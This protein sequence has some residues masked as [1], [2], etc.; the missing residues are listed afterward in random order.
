MTTVEQKIAPPER[1]GGQGLDHNQEE[2]ANRAIIALLTDAKEGHLTD[3]VAT[4]RHGPPDE[5]AM[6]TAGAY[7]VWAQRGMVR[8]RRFYEPDG[9]YGYEVIEQVGENPIGNQ[10]PTALATLAEE[11]EAGAKSGFSGEDPA[12]AFVEPAHLSHPLAYER[13]A[14][15]FDSP[16]GPD[17]VV[18]PK[19]YAWGRQPGQH[20]SIDVVQSRAPLVFSGPGIRHGTTDALCAQVDVAPTLAKLLD[21]PLIDGMDSTGRT[22]SERGVAPDVYLKRQDGRVIESVLDTERGELRSRPERVYVFLL[23]GLSNTE[24]KERLEHDRESIPALSRL[25]DHGAF[26]EYGTIVNFP[27]I[28]WPSHNALGTGAWC[29]HH[30]IVNP[31]YHLRETKETITP[32]GMTWDT[33]RFLGAGVETFY[34]AVHRVRGKWDPVTKQGAVTASI[35]EPCSRGAAH[36]TL[37][38]QLLVSGEAIR[39]VARENK[40]DTNARWKAEA[41]EACYR[42]SGTD[43][44]GLAQALLLFDNDE[45]PP[46]TFTYHEF[47]LNDSVGHDYGPH[48]DAVRDSLIETDKRISKILALLDRKG[49]FDSTLFV[50]TTDHGMAPID[51][52]LAA[53]QVRAVPDAGIKS[54]TCMPLVY[55]IDMDVTVSAAPDGRTVTVTVVD[56]DS[57]AHGEKVPVGGARVEVAA[58]HARVV[59]EARTDAYGVAG[60]PLP[61]DID[62]VD[63]VVVVH[64]DD[65]NSRHLWLNGENVV[66]D[67]RASL[68][69]AT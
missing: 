19:S 57:D 61:V 64:H 14:Q 30:D 45:M 3:I 31:T 41:Q 43:I 67:P 26:F 40:E 11:L 55:L 54:V 18:S 51:T 33:G 34:E 9:G 63:F 44:Q 58:P 2:S 39:A 62:P 48:S 66:E 15:L 49:L 42:Y 47:S 27:S 46:P 13:I 53:D 32:Q 21:F 4:Y 17:L 20:G 50:V 1:F 23:D 60:L 69:G 8:F 16:N 37:E 25:I 52:E 22:S 59:A 5:D 12:R 68:Y 56:N 6:P 7:E 28:T 65:F 35:N 36:S 24:L 29:G 38:R 10:D